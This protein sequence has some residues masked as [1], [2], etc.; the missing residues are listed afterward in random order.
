MTDIACVKP[1]YQAISISTC[2][3]YSFG[4]GSEMMRDGDVIGLLP[5]LLRSQKYDCKVLNWLVPCNTD[6]SGL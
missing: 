5:T 6:S 3:F 1:I 2:P 4:G